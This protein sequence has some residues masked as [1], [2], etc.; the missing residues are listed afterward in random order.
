MDEIPTLISI[1]EATRAFAARTVRA[2][3]PTCL[4]KTEHETSMVLLEALRQ[5]SEVAQ[6]GWYSPPPNG[7]TVLAA[8]PPYSRLNYRSLRE[9]ENW[10][11]NN[12]L[13]E[14]SVITC[15]VSPVHRNS[16]MIGDFGGTFYFGNNALLHRHIARCEL[17]VQELIPTF[18]QGMTFDQIYR[19]SHEAFRKH[20]MTNQPSKSKTDPAGTNLGHTV[21]FAFPSE[22]LRTEASEENS[23]II[24][25]SRQF[26]SEGSPIRLPNQGCFIFEAQLRD[27]NDPTL[28]TILVHRIVKMDCGKPVMLN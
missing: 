28:P 25:N 11:S 15:Y 7:I 17:L 5:N 12:I 8:C 26:L 13:T 27:N 4:G 19:N 9:P 3:L 24:S 1:C 23:K 14:D 2:V 10:P 20:E 18:H 6:E 21:P 16:L 22:S